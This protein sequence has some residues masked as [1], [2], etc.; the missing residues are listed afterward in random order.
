MKA[1]RGRRSFHGAFLGLKPASAIPKNQVKNS[2]F[3]GFNRDN[4]GNL[5]ELVSSFYKTAEDDSNLLQD[6]NAYKE[7]DNSLY[8]I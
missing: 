8:F 5:A 6:T 3:V 7:A 1:I 2:Q 4:G